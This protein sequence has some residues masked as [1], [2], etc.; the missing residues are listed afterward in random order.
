[1]RVAEAL[2]DRLYAI[3][4]DT[5]ASRRGDFYRILEEVRWELNLRGY[6]HIKIF[7]SGGIDEDDVLALNPV[8]DAYGV[9]TCIS[10]APVID[11]AMDIVEIEGK[12]I[13][14]RGKM[15]GAKDVLRCTVCGNDRV[16]PLG[17][18]LKKCECGGAYINLLAP[19]FAA[20]KAV[21]EHRTPSEIRDYVIAQLERYH[22]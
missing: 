6:D 22:L 1:M 21:H 20:G 8:V 7:V 3:R 12:P 15:S 13:A 2:Q 16:I 18:N 10:N 14:K 9:G 11:F 19:L 17:R 4:L 5:P